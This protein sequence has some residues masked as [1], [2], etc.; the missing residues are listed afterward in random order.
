MAECGVDRVIRLFI[1]VVAGRIYVFNIF[2]LKLDERVDTS[3]F[4][5]LFFFFILITISIQLISLERALLRR[6]DAC[7]L[8][9]GRDRRKRIK[10]VSILAERRVMA[11]EKFIRIEFVLAVSAHEQ[12]CGLHGA[13]TMAAL[14]FSLLGNLYGCTRC[15]GAHK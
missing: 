1:T 4:L 11:N 14:L 8:T 10:S 13:M 2:D 9:L 15:E 7:V 5:S 6:R 12:L 3:L